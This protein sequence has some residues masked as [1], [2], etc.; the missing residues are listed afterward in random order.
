MT[1]Y[2]LFTITTNTVYNEI[3]CERSPLKLKQN[4]SRIFKKKFIFSKVP[5]SRNEF[6]PTY[7]SRF[8]LKVLVILSM[9]F[10]RTA[11]VNQNCY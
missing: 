11:S 8:L 10:G 9:I 2:N 3:F 6:I 5:D 7:F 4:L 1:V